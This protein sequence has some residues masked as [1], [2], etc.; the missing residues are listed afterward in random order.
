L[1]VI[2]RMLKFVLLTLEMANQTLGATEY[3]GQYAF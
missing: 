1:V 2:S 3:I